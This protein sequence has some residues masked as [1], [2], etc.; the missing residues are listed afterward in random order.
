MGDVVVGFDCVICMN[1]VKFCVVYDCMVILCNYF[2]YIK[3]LMWW[4][5]IK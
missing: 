3:C 5:D 1:L 2:F 4:M